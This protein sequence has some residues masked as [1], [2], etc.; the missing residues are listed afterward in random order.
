MNEGVRSAARVLDLLEYFATASEGL[1]LTTLSAVFGMPKSSTLAL[2]RTLVTRGYVVRDEHGL[3]AL[4]DVFRNRGFGWGSDAHARLA[5]V[6]QPAMDALCEELGETVILGWLSDDGYVRL[7]A[8]S[9][10]Q[11]VVRYDV[12]LGSESPAYC[13][14][15]GRAVLSRWPRAHR[16]AVLGAL[17]RPAR[18]PHTLTDLARIN[19]RIDEATKA[20]YT[21]AHEEYALDGIGI[22]MPI[23][24]SEGTALGALNVG[25]VASRFEGKR[26]KIIAALKAC[27]DSLPPQFY[28][29]VRETLD[30]NPTKSAA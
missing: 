1:A 24:D 23:C 25:C 27:I 11:T 13:T 7:L 9:V 20:G 17:P 8:K 21:I 22:A 18:T 2:L 12:D 16:D 30:D 19:E 6:A 3:Y 26:E 28:A 29:P 14:A 4:N 5:A 15:I 10:T